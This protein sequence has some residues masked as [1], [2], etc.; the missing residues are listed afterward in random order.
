MQSKAFGQKEAD[1]ELLMFTNRRKRANPV[2]LVRVDKNPDG[3]SAGR[4]IEE[5]D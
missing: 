4:L 2:N 5:L 3:D 1:G